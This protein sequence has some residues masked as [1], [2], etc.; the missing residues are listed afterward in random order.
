MITRFR[1]ELR[2]AGEAED[3][4]ECGWEVGRSTQAHEGG[5]TNEGGLRRGVEGVVDKS[6]AL[7]EPGQ[8]NPGPLGM[9]GSDGPAAAQWE[10]A[11]FARELRLLP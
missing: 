1:S 7:R 11:D 9:G 8:Y 4:C 5:D 6:P 2:K 10:F 3:N